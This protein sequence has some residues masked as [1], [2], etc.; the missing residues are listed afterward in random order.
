MIAGG[1]MSVTG[2]EKMLKVLGSLP[3]SVKESLVGGV[4]EAAAEP[5]VRAA[6]SKAPVETGELRASIHST[7]PR[8]SGGKIKCKIL[9]GAGFFQGDIFYSGFIEFGHYQGSR[10][11]GTNR[12][13]ISPRPF[14]RPAADEQRDS[15]ISQMVD[16]IGNALEDRYKA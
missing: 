11:L 9:A 13:F 10:S 1:G 16:G 12:P 15:A 5:I 7:K 4:L 8:V 6:K 2:L 14:M 3:D